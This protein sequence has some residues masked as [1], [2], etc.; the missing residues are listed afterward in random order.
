MDF[1]EAINLHAANA[2]SAFTGFDKLIIQGEENPVGGNQA[3]ALL[4]SLNALT[5]RS[6]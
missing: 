3:T 5:L 4:H 6:L 2:M 1:V